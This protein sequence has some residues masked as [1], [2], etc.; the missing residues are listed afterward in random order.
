MSL[1]TVSNRQR[2]LN[3]LIRRRSKKISKF[4]VTGL[5]EE[6][7]PVTGEF[8]APRASNAENGSIWW[9]HHATLFFAC[10]TKYVSHNRIVLIVRNLLHQN[11]PIQN[12]FHKFVWIMCSAP[13]IK[14][15]HYYN[16]PES[17]DQTN[18]FQYISISSEVN[19]LGNRTKLEVIP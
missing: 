11:L 10:S 6:T 3:R 13:Y 19:T 12:I 15:N 8:P 18:L 9:R 14:C 2:F 5:C 7:S 1:M 4:R 16:L 17:K